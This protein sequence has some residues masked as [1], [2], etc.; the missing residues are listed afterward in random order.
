M[1]GAYIH[2]CVRSGHRYWS[3]FWFAAGKLWVLGGDGANHSSFNDMWAYDTVGAEWALVYNRTGD[4][5]VGVYEGDAQFPGKRENAFTSVSDTD[6]AL[7]MFGGSGYGRFL[8][9]SGDMNDLWR[10]DTQTLK[11]TFEGGAYVRTS[12]ARPGRQARPLLPALS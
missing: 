1:R 4:D 11:W 9:E 3:N 12:A 5:E 7:W 8:N 2:A 10:F 6:G